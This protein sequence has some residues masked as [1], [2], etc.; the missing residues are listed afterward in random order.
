MV[1]LTSKLIMFRILTVA[2]VCLVALGGKAQ[3][4][5][6]LNMELLS[7]LTY[8]ERLSDVWAY[9]APNG[10]EYAIVGTNTATSVVSLVDPRN[11]VEV[12]SFPGA[13]SI[14]RD[15][16]HLGEYVYVTTDRGSDGLLVIDM[17][18]APDNIT[19]EFWSPE[20]IINEDTTSLGACHN[21]FIDEFG[22]GYLAGCNLNSGAPLIIDL[23]TTPGQPQYVGPASSTESHDVMAQNNLLY[24][25]EIR[26]GRFSVYDVSDKLNPTLLASQFT[27]MFFTHNAWVSDDGNFIFTTDE[28]ANAYVDSYDISDLMD[29]K[30]LDSWQPEA[31]KGS[32]V[33]PHNTHYLNG[34]LIT[35]WYSDG[36]RIIDGNKP[37][38]LV[39]VAFFDTFPDEEVGFIGVWGATPYLPSGLVL[40][41]DIGTGLYV[42]DVD[43][44]RAS[45]LEGNVTDAD[46]GFPIG[47][48]FVAIDSPQLNSE[49]TDALGDYKTGLADAGAI[50]VTF[51]ADGYQSQTLPTTL[52]SGE[53]TEL[54]V[55]LLPGTSTS[56]KNL[57]TTQIFTSNPN[58]FSHST[59]LNFDE[60]VHGQMVVTNLLG[61]QVETIQI[62][63]T[64]KVEVGQQYD[65][66]VYLINL[67]SDEKIYQAVKIVKQ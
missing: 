56:T 63:N 45:Y 59:V 33:I 23:F 14:W 50:M 49:S 46:T 4:Q 60:S 20:I 42:F 35:S 58:P 9:A 36:V 51:S 12:A 11:P 57:R 55:A 27:S 47:D 16:K 61:Q 7:N 1:L 40:A 19:A 65:A 66:G 67:T 39:E 29:I 5:G 17:K 10:D 6:A 44:A 24:S 52:Q 28:R 41:S 18:D 31:S 25:S 64:T 43:Y 3:D 22:Y 32:G 37:D 15:I 8:G 2:L 38:N 53:V 54:D 34:Y 26:N 62:V 48:V 21:I 30:R 13:I